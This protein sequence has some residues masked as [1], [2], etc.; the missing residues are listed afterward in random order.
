M[1]PTS[2]LVLNF[3]SNKSSQNSAIQYFSRLDAATYSGCLWPFLCLCPLFFL[4]RVGGSWRN[5]CLH[6]LTP[7]GGGA[8]DTILSQNHS[9]AHHSSLC[10]HLSSRSSQKSSWFKCLTTRLIQACLDEFIWGTIMPEQK[11]E[12]GLS[13]YYKVLLNYN[14]FTK[15]EAYNCPKII[16]KLARIL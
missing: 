3:C 16:D 7:H 5:T 9:P 11:I 1:A 13:L 6:N 10:C 14:Y 12:P 15:F 8:R 4:L 2:W